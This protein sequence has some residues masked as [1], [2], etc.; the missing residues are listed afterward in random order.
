M[1]RLN[2]R[3]SNYELTITNN[4]SEANYAIQLINSIKDGLQTFPSLQRRGGL[5]CRGGEVIK[6][7]EFKGCDAPNQRNEPDIP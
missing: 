4:L 1:N 2:G 6:R 5:E 7:D 3:C